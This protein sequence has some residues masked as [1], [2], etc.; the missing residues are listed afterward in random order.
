MAKRGVRF[1]LGFIFLAVLVSVAGVVL[2]FLVVGRGP[3]VA[4]NSTLV[5]RLDDDLREAPNDNVVQQ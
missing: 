5:L 1:V 4:G 2:M 3:S